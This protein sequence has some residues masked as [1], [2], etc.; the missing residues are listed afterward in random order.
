[1][2][3]VAPKVEPY[4]CADRADVW[5]EVAKVIEPKLRVRPS[6][7]A[8]RNIRLR[9]GDA[10]HAGPMDMDFMPWT[11]EVM[12]MVY[13]HPGKKGM[14]CIKPSQIGYTYC[15]L[16]LMLCYCATDPSPMLYVIDRMDK[17]GKF[18]QMFLRWIED[19][20]ELKGLL[21]NHKASPTPTVVMDGMELDFHTAGSEGGLTTLARRYI[22]ID[23]A[24]ASILAYPKERG[25]LIGAAEGRFPA[26][27]D[28]SELFAWGHPGSPDKDIDQ[29]VKTASDQRPWVW[30]CPHCGETVNP[31]WD[32]VHFGG[33]RDG[34][35]ATLD[36]TTAAFMCPNCAVEISDAER[37]K[38][39]RS[40]RWQ[41]GTGRFESVLDPQ[42]AASRLYLGAVIH[43]LSAPN[44]TVRS[45]A[46]QYV[47][48][49][50]RGDVRAFK[51]K[52][53]GET[54]QP[55]L[56]VVTIQDVLACVKVAEREIILPGG[57]DGAHILTVGIDVQF[58]KENP[59]L[60]V[61]AKAW[62]ATGYS[63]VTA[64]ER[65]RGWAACMNWLSQYRVRRDHPGGQPDWITP[66]AVGV[67]CGWQ[68]GAVL[69]ACRMQIVSAHNGSII[70]MV[71]MR[72]QDF[73]KSEV[74]AV[75]RRSVDPLRPN[76]GPIEIFNLHDDT[77]I[78][79]AV[80]RI[81]DARQV[82]LCRPPDDWVQQLTARSLVQKKSVHGWAE[83]AATWEKQDKKRRDD[84]LMSC[85][86]AEVIAS[87]RLGLDQ[88]HEINHAVVVAP[89]AAT[90]AEPGGWLADPGGQWLGD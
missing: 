30:D 1:M 38:A 85:V 60:Y 43:R 18:Y 67:D 71:P 10:A 5:A 56:G 15:M 82:V 14:F 19:N 76:L 33:V 16:A 61:V 13:D 6:Q 12:D 29:L 17:T 75:A 26:Y 72:F 46:G 55:K 79:R 21:K 84:W 27:A 73:V 40:R 45:L 28:T 59:T 64:A 4:P 37:T 63:Y 44:V 50:K 25:D 3:A 23:E 22:F 57:N 36:P 69:D 24:E 32:C 49:M 47:A 83:Q 20:A 89:P 31:T 58:P 90:A 9:V 2:N 86:Y 80:R 7:W 48:A 54:D 35:D 68:T 88:L 52:Q 87:T 66:M 53:L 42:D 74:P 51:N 34:D 41:G 11:R 62:A 70:P 77:W 8:E 65:I 81:Q 39:T 78:S